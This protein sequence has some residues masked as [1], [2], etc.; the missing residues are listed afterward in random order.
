MG[1]HFPST[2][3]L[4]TQSC[5]CRGG[6][7]GWKAWVPL[8]Q[9][10]PEASLGVD[11]GC[12]WKGRA[13][14]RETRWPQLTRGGLQGAGWGCE[15]WLRGAFQ[16]EGHSPAKPPVWPLK[17]DLTVVTG[18]QLALP[19]PGPSGGVG[20]PSPPLPGGHKVWCTHVPLL[21]PLHTFCD[22]GQVTSSSGPLCLCPKMSE[23]QTDD[24]GTES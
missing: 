7:Q 6:E 9:P 4:L 11:G 10:L 5:L 18:K 17:Q 19:G 2:A 1:P 8:P 12:G 20:A 24:K 14:G 15:T 22:F 23:L 16:S 21:W 3:L 13:W